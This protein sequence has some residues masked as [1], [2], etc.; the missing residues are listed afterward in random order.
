MF[1]KM[2]SLNQIKHLDENTLGKPILSLREQ[3]YET[4]HF[5]ISWDDKF[6]K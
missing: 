3:A 4:Y 6:T 2:Q 1:D 5:R